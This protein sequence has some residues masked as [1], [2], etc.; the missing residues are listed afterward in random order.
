MSQQLD[1]RKILPGKQGKLMTGDGKFLA[2]VNTFQAIININNSDY[3]PA[4]SF[5]VVA[6]M[7]GYTVAL[8]FTETVVNDAELFKKLMDDIKAGK[9]PNLD[10]QGVITGLNGSENR[11]IFRSCVPDGSIDLQNINVGDIIQRSWG[12]RVNETPDM[13]SYLQQ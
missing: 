9:Q 3:Q 6:I 8:N 10:F 2:T 11:Q 1:P 5:L 12:F 13:Q 7:M 4:G